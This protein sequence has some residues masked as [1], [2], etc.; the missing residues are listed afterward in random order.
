MIREDTKDML[1]GY[2]VKTRRRRLG[3][4]KDISAFNLAQH[5]GSEG[6]IESLNIP[7]ILVRIFLVTYS[8]NYKIDM[9]TG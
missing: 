9:N 2:T 7:A 3:R 4:L 5:L 8:V 6:K 1:Q